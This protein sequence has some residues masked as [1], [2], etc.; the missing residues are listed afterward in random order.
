MLQSVFGSRIL[1][2]DSSAARA[3]ADIATIRR[4]RGRPVPPT[5]CQIAAIAYSRNMAIVTRN[6]RDFDSVG[7]EVLDPWAAT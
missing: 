2:F 3:Y 4:S 5:D 1:P 7:I 6:V